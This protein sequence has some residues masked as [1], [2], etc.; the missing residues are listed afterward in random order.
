M[1]DSEKSLSAYTC[2]LGTAPSQVPNALFVVQ[3]AIVRFSWL[4]LK[5]TTQ[6]PFDILFGYAISVLANG[7]RLSIESITAANEGLFDFCV[8]SDVA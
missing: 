8:T 7:N 6:M 4:G 3:S 2:R 5:M 1:L